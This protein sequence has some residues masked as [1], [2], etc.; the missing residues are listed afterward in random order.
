VSSGSGIRHFS[1]WGSLKAGETHILKKH[2][3]SLLC[4][5]VPL[6][7]LSMGYMM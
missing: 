2:L 6:M 7:Y 3:I 5:P 1:E 4:L